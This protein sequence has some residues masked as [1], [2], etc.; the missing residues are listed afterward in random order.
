MKCPICGAENESNSTFCT[1]CGNAIVNEVKEESIINEV[2]S[3][4]PVDEVVTEE[5]IQP[6]E[7]VVTEEIVQPVEEIV[8]VQ[9]LNEEVPTFEETSSQSMNSVDFNNTKKKGNGLKILLAVLV[10]VILGVS[11][12]FLY[13]KFFQNPAT[14]YKTAL[15]DF[16]K[17]LSNTITGYDTVKADFEISPE[18]SMKDNNPIVDLINKFKVKASASIDYK[19]SKLSLNLG[20][21]YDDGEL[22]NADIIYN[23]KAYITLNNILS[24]SIEI[25]DV[26]LKDLFK[27]SNNEDAKV[28]IEEYTS[29]LKGSL[30]DKYFTKKS[31]TIKV[32]DKDVKTDVYVM[33][34][35]EKVAV[36]LSKNIIN[37]L[38]DNDKFIASFARVS[39]VSE[40]EV[41]EELKSASESFTE[42]SSETTDKIEIRL[43]TKGVKHD[44]VRLE[45]IVNGTSVMYTELGNDEY[46]VSIKDADNSFQVRFKYSVEYNKELSI[47]TPSKTIKYTQLTEKDMTDMLN[48][49]SKNK[50]ITKLLTD[51]G[52]DQATMASLIP[53]TGAMTY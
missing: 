2:V 51:L 18:I 16:S 42:I 44:F 5:T 9:T 29:A 22:L 23:S 31:E 45:L 36:E 28:L 20:A 4:E 7:E 13:N 11:G 34:I 50:A 38:K 48:A 46:L 8:P 32:N 10:L 49:I 14:I 1:N 39:N 52:L 17:E 43:Y 25:D 21:L 30:K 12:Y 47:E 41:K 33:S 24:K 35:D 53:S 15:T 40:S 6:V 37:K 26:D 19:N 27:K 3:T